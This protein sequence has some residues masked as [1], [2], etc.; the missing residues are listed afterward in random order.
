[1]K[2]ESNCA[3]TL[4]SPI[5]STENTQRFHSK[6]TRGTRSHDGQQLPQHSSHDHE[7]SATG[8]ELEL[9][10]KPESPKLLKLNFTFLHSDKLRP[11]DT[12][13][14]YTSNARPSH[15]L[16][17]LLYR[18]RTRPQAIN[19]SENCVFFFFRVNHND[20]TSCILPMQHIECQ[21]LLSSWTTTLKKAMYMKRIEPP[22]Q[23]T[24]NSTTPLYYHI[25]ARGQ[26]VFPGRLVGGGYL[27]DIVNLFSWF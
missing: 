14:L 27:I 17:L 3:K 2:N 20:V 6:V 24:G 26:F 23:A 19:P 1:M 4:F 16:P 11:V 7:L 21:R 9:V 8:Y 15:N 10:Q 5:I 25:F 22:A 13:T 12:N 18:N